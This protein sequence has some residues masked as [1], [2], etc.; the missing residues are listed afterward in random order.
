M[1][2]HQ[3]YTIVMTHDGLFEKAYPVKGAEIGFEVAYEPFTKN[4]NSSRLREKFFTVRVIAIACICL[5][6]LFPLYMVVNGDEAYAYV[7]IDINPS[8]ELEVNS[9]L[10]ITNVTPFNEEAELIIHELGDLTGKEIDDAIA[11]I[12]MKSEDKGFVNSAKNVLIGVHYI[13]ETETEP[14][15]NRIDERFE[16]TDWELVTIKIPEDV[17]VVAEE[18]NQS[19]NEALAKKVT[20]E[21][22]EELQSIV[23][24]ED[25]QVLQSFYLNKNAKA[26]VTNEKDSNQVIQDDTNNADNEE[27]ELNT[28]KSNSLEKN[29]NSNEQKKNKH[30]ENHP[31]KSKES[32]EIKGNNKEKHPGMNGKDKKSQNKQ[33]TKGKDKT[34]DKHQEKNHGKGNGKDKGN[35]VVMTK[36]LNQVAIITTA[37]TIMG[38]NMV[39]TTKIIPTCDDTGWE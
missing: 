21:P 7:D 30:K 24:E 16:T 6:M 34:N 1:E 18:N 11:I 2:Q 35:S 25:S 28:S 5:I 9:S 12:M 37:T 3:K 13:K 14:I 4:E 23:T 31:K 19:M 29:R 10:E 26:D 15:I 39:I 33:D 22:D 17:R 36:S 8:M 38:K 32:K 20:E 27:L